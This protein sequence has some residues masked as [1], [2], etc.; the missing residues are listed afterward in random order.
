MYRG[1]AQLPYT[2]TCLLELYVRKLCMV[3]VDVTF[4]EELS[5]AL[6]FHNKIYQVVAKNSEQYVNG[7]V[8]MRSLYNILVHRL[9]S[10]YNTNLKVQYMHVLTSYCSMFGPVYQ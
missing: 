3:S 9:I 1:I 8:L 4:I 5:S 6:M 10:Y 7:V 2:A